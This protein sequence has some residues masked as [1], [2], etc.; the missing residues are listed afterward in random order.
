MDVYINNDRHYRVVRFFTDYSAFQTREVLAS[1]L[2]LDEAQRFAES[3]ADTPGEEI[4]VQDQ[5]KVGLEAEVETL[6]SPL[7]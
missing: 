6:H 3:Q 2:T 7:S 5:N 1:D 4:A